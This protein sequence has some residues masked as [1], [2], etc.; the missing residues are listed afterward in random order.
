MSDINFGENLTISS[1]RTLTLSALLLSASCEAFLGEI[2]N[3]IFAVPDDV[4]GA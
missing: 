4:S 3:P 1:A 2:L